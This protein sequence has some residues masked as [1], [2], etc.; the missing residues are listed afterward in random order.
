MNKMGFS[1]QQDLN[2]LLAAARA[3][4]KDLNHPQALYDYKVTLLGKKGQLTEIL[5]GLGQVAPD[6]RR[7]VGQ[8]VNDVKAELTAL[9]EEKE[10]ILAEAGLQ[11]RLEQER[12][13]V[14][15]S[16]RHNTASGLHPISRSLARIT[17]FFELAG[18]SVAEGPELEDEFHNF[19]ALNIPENHPARA[20]HDTFYFSDGRLLRT[21]TSNVQIREMQK[22]P[23]P[24]R[25]IA[26]GRVY[27]CDSDQTHT[28]MFHQVEGL[29]V[30]EQVNFANLKGLL[31]LFLQDFFEKEV[32]VR[33]RPSFFPFTEPSAEV[34]VWFNNRWLEVL[35]CGMVHPNVLKNVGIDSSRYQGLA[36]GLGLERL[37]MVRYGITDLR[38]LYEN[39]MRFLKGF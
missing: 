24:I 32:R 19:S 11:V 17:K 5:K 26:P 7:E 34:D 10:Q 4:I 2:E 8:L 22:Q 30:D 35:G 39:D 29:W 3:S 31:Q 1:V 13:D 23:G 18:F 36:F 37:T 16:G 21:H 28:P 14:S 25:L 27:R 12:I 33:F 6:V 9:F 38:M 15:L 20:S